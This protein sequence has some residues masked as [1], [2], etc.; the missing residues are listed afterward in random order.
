MTLTL[1]TDFINVCKTGKTK[2]RSRTAILVDYCA[3]GF[4]PTPLPAN[5]FCV[6]FRSRV[7]QKMFVI[8]IKVFH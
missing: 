3:V 8:V 2:S 7:S 4:S 6:K 5:L 1:A